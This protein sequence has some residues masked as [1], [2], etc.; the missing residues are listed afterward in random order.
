MTNKIVEVNEDEIVIVIRP[1]L[2][3]N[4]EWI[5]ETSV[6]FSKKHFE[7]DKTT[8][9]ISELC[10]AMVGF[11]YAADNDD[12]LLYSGIFYKIIDGDFRDSRK[13]VQKKDNVIYLD[14][15]TDE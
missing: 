5:H 15:F 7:D 13:I 6:H 2:D 3:K 4:K 11:S 1:K 12:I 9:A 8:I 14:K 10:R